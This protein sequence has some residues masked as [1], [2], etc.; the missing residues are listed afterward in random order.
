MTQITPQIATLIGTTGVAVWM[1]IAGMHKNAL[2]L[3]REK[4]KC[5]SCGLH[6]EGRTCGRHSSS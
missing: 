3:R 5:P 4:R 2:E 1:V 6:I